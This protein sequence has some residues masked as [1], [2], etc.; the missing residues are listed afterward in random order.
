MKIEST[1]I[2]KINEC[3]N[4]I[5]VASTI[6]NFGCLIT[7]IALDIFI[8]YK[9][10][11]KEEILKNKVFLRCID[12]KSYFE[13]VVL[14]VPVFNIG[15]ACAAL[16]DRRSIAPKEESARQ[17]IKKNLISLQVFQTQWE[18]LSQMDAG[19]WQEA[20]LDKLYHLVDELQKQL[21]THQTHVPLE[22]QAAYKFMLLGISTNIS[23]IKI[24]LEADN[25]RRN[26][27][28]QAP[29]EKQAA[30][31]C[32][33][34]DKLLLASKPVL[35]QISNVNALLPAKFLAMDH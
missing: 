34:K 15:F 7:K 2:I 9:Q 1:N 31:Y 14:M 23:N 17:A 4:F 8:Q 29:I 5:P 18:Q 19:Q 22:L 20:D 11:P 21:A 16:V 32:S 24:F 10:L 33:L 26:Q 12:H 28:N 3:I 35:E 6:T 27:I 25:N 13:I 30:Y